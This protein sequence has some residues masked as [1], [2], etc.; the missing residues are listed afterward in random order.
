MLRSMTNKNFFQNVLYYK[1]MFTSCWVTKDFKI[2]LHIRTM[3]SVISNWHVG[4]DNKW[5]D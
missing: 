1:L 4:I 5:M 3:F 2:R